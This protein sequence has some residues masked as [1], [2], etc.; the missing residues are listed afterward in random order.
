[1]R[2]PFFQSL[3][4]AHRQVNTEANQAADTA[5]V[6]PSAP[7]TSTSARTEVESWMESYR[8][9]KSYKLGFIAIS[10]EK[11]ALVS[12]GHPEETKVTWSQA[13]LNS[14]N[15]MLDDIDRSI[16]TGSIKRVIFITPGSDC[17]IFGADLNEFV[18]RQTPDDFQQA[19]DEGHRIFARVRNLPVKTVAAVQGA[20][21]GGGLE[22]ALNCDEIVACRSKGAVSA[23]FSSEK[24]KF[25][26]PEIML[27]LFPGWGGTILAPRKIG[28][29]A[30]D[31]ILTGRDVKIDEALR[32]GLID[33]IAPEGELLETAEMAARHK[34]SPW[35]LQGIKRSEKGLM[36]D[37]KTYL[38]QD[39]PA[40]YGYKYPWFNKIAETFMGEKVMKQ[41]QS[42]A[43]KGM[44]SFD[45]TEQLANGPAALNVILHGLRFGLD[46]GL[47]FERTEVTR[48][49]SS[50]RTKSAARFH[51]AE[52]AVNTAASGITLNPIEQS[53]AIVGA[54]V[55]GGGI[56]A[57]FATRGAWV[58]VSD[59]KPE[60]LRGAEKRVHDLILKAKAKGSLT[61]REAEIC[62]DHFFTHFDRQDYSDA[63]IVIE[64]ISEN[65]ELKKKVLP[66]IE[67]TLSPDAILAT[68]TS[69]KPVSEIAKTLERPGNFCG[70]HF[71]NPAE[72]MK[73]VEVVAGEATSV[74]TLEQAKALVKSIGKIPVVVKDVPGFLVNRIL[75]RYLGES[76]FLLQDGFYPKDIDMAGR[77]AGFFMGPID[78]LDLVGLDIGA[79]VQ[80]TLAAAY[81]ERMRFPDLARNLVAA[82]HIGRKSGRG[83]HDYTRDPRRSVPIS[84]PR[85]LAELFT[86][87]LSSLSPYPDLD[88]IGKRL[89]FPI[90]DEAVRCLDQGVAGT[91]GR[92]A[93]QQID[94][95]MVHGSGALAIHAGP[96]AYAERLGA[97]RVVQEMDALFERT[98]AARYIPGPSLL[99]RARQN[100]S[101]Y[102][103]LFVGDN[104]HGE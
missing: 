67:A 85:A 14:L 11:T 23:Y 33:R 103:P 25:A 42:A 75:I 56:A 35:R 19:I 22:F 40:R 46:A 9:F 38:A 60:A 41:A 50:A 8:P 96:I 24:T 84:D 44:K 72:T 62:R 12:L 88:Y 102:E 15:T 55:M 21:V 104:D 18:T 45:P 71:F 48:F 43:E 36:T 32:I 101:F 39:W 77:H 20:C 51:F 79:E 28:L 97:K 83:F 86:G 76:Q 82:G 87:N 78:T 54:G 94:V 53:V 61:E 17:F 16:S 57:S 6:G 7:H 73:L 70:I 1:M 59:M 5:L 66:E 74:Q 68:N 90:I 30:I 13:R 91:P 31:L 4:A 47:D 29:Q 100:I 2:P 52:K 80:M 69:S 65:L 37:L 92:F 98:G 26:F 81:G 63:D 89:T 27:G 64:A 10:G 34:G 93:A 95:A 49:I 3:A 99:E 58:R